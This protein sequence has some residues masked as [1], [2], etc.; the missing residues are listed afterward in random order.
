MKKRFVLA[1]NCLPTKAPWAV[2]LLLY[3]F[4][5]LY[6]SSTVGSALL[7]AFVVVL[8]LAFLG[9]AVIQQEVNL[10]ED[11]EKRINGEQKS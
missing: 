4:D 10:F 7:A 9:T 3:M 11:Y 5:D 2:S 6:V 8:W 1:S